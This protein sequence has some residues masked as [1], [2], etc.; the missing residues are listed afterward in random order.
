MSG[1]AWENGDKEHFNGTLRREVP[2][3]EWVTTTEQAQIGTNHWL[4][5][6]NHA[7]PHPALN[8]RPPGPE[9]P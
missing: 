4:R 2:N 6:Y 1:N 8:M 9:T 7:R 5:Q 3:G